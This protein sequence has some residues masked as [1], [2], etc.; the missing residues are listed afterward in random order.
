[1]KRLL[2][3]LCIAMLLAVPGAEA[4]TLWAAAGETVKN[5]GTIIAKNRD[6]APNHTQVLRKI[7]PVNGYRY[8]GLFAVGGDAPGLK[9][10]MNEHGLVVVSATAGSIPK[11]ERKA[12]PSVQNVNAKLL[13]SC[14]SVDAALAK[15]ELFKGPRYL[16][17]AD[18]HKIAYIEIGP[19]GKHI[20]RVMDQGFLYHTNH[21]VD[22]SMLQANRKVGVSSQTRYE[23]IGTLLAEAGSPF[24]MP[25]F[26]AFS[27]DRAA[28]PDNS[29]WR[30]G[31]KPQS[32][33]TLSTWIVHQLPSGDASLYI[34]LANPDEAETVLRLKASDIFSGS[35]GF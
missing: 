17:L 21:Y 6:W 7:T 33:R 2:S 27:Q 25:D 32:G 1:M 12:M 35:A 16:M 19:E 30:T 20:I 22:E 11:K 14:D 18:R 9:G 34:V 28:G 29:I 13:T 24:E 4:C 15:T 23:R 3:V 10:G 8:F 5:G 26:I 31:G